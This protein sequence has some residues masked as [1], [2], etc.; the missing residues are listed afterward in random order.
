MLQETTSAVA[1]LTVQ[2]MCGIL[3]TATNEDYRDFSLFGSTFDTTLSIYDLCGG[4]ELA[5]NNDA[6]GSQ[7]KLALYL[8]SGSTYFIRIAGNNAEVGDYF[9][10]V[11]KP[12]CLGEVVGDLTGDCK[13]DF[14]DFEL[15]ARNWIECNLDP[16][17]ACWE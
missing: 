9:L 11:G 4:T 8:T 13:I 14:A 17:E 12:E 15:M 1:A 3:N 10:T 16:P 2:A 7:S 6:C 5:C